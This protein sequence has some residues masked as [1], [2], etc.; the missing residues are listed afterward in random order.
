MDQHIQKYE[1]LIS[2]GDY[3]SE[4]AETNMQ[5]FC[6]SYFLKNMVRKQTCF[7]NPA[8]PT[9]NDALIINEPG[10]FWNAKTYETGLSHF[11]KLVVSISGIKR[12]RTGNHLIHKPTNTYPFSQTDQII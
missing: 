9:C 12:T 11:H 10:M 6:E 8:K 2:M 3:N 1:N 5:E 7:K 4:A